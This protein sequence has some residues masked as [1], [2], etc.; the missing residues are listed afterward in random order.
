MSLLSSR[1]DNSKRGPTA[2]A[3]GHADRAAVIVDSFF[4]NGEPEASAGLFG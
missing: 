4:H 3:R 1:Q 2:F